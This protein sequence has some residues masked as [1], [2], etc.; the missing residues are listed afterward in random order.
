MSNAETTFTF[1]PAMQLMAGRLFGFAATFFVPIV[2]VRHFAPEVFGTYKQIF[3]VYTTVFALGQLGIA[4]SL[5]YFLPQGRDDRDA[6]AGYQ[7]N[8][9][10]VLSL[11]GATALA[12]LILAARPIASLL[13]NPAL[14]PHL[15]L[16]GLYLLLSLASAGLEITLLCRQRFVRA[17]AVYALSDVLRAVLLVLPVLLFGD[18]TWMMAGAIAFAATRLAVHVLA[19]RRRYGSSLRPNRALLAQQLGYSLPFQLAVVVEVVQGSLHQYAVSAWFDPATFALYAVGCLQIPLVD[20]AASSAGNVLMV[21]MG[22][23]LRRGHAATA[24][25]IWLQTTRKLALLLFPLVVVLVLLAS[26]L[27]P[28][29][30]TSAYRGSVPVFVV[31]TCAVT[32]SALQ[33]DS[34]L[35]VYAAVRTILLL[36]LVRLAVVGALIAWAVSVAGLVGAVLATVVAAAVAKGLALARLR[37]LLDV[38]WSRVLPWQQLFAIATAS[39][40]AAVPAALLRPRLDRGEAATLV[41]LGATYLVVLLPLLA[42]SGIVR[43]DEIPN[44]ARRLWR[45]FDRRLGPAP[46]EAA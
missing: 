30:F 37:R 43:P 12:V 8:A 42:A 19:L 4:E 13:N 27:I 38:A 3:L 16:L 36:N 23:A 39:I 17:A 18:L 31:W 24:R 33:T 6:R 10:I 5:F 1:R 28:F 41:V 44:P 25:D 14:A 46:R 45:L 2:L 11:S 29:L 32:L 40:V 34:A 21:G 22:D 26:D 9:L 20:F 35:R 7:A 15:P